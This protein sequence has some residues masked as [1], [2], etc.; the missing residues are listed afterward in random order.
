VD[1]FDTLNTQNGYIHRIQFKADDATRK[2]V[3]GNVEN[4]V[5]LK[6]IPAAEL[7]YITTISADVVI[8]PVSKK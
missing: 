6:N 7:S 3:H 1:S 5:V 2:Y 8:K 4:P